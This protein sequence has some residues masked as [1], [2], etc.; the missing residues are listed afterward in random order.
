MLHRFLLFLT[1]LGCFALA[2]MAQPSDR[3]SSGAIQQ[4]LE[5]LNTLGTVLY[6]AAHPDD[7]NT[8]LISHLANGKHWR[9]AYFS[10]TRGD[11]GQ[12]LIGTEITQGLGVIRTQELLAARRLDGG[13]QFFSRA[14]DF[15]YSKH[16]DETFSVWD[17][18]QA[19]SDLVWV[20]RKLRPDVI[21]TRFSEEP[22]VTH[23][24][25]TASAILAH[26]AF[27]LANDP[28]AFPQ[29]LQWVQPWQ[30]AKLFWNIGLWSYRQSGRTFD[31]TGFVKE[32]VGGFNPYLGKSYTELSAAS[33][34]MHKS[35]G[36]GAS[37][38][39]GSE[40][41]YFQQW[42]GENTG[43]L[44]GGIPTGWG[45]VAGSERVAYYLSE[46]R[47][48]YDPAEPESIL[49]DLLNAR[50]ELMQLPDQHWKSVKLKE[51][52]TCIQSVTGTYMEVTA[53]APAYT[54]GDSVQLRLEVVNRTKAPIRLASARFFPAN[55]KL[56]YQLELKENQRNEFAL[57]TVLPKKTPYSGPYWLEHPFSQGMYYVPDQ[58][59]IGQAEN[60]PSLSAEFVL[61]LG[62]QEITYAVP[63]RYKRTDPVKGEVY[64]PVQVV[65]AVMVQLDDKALIFGSDQP[66]QV[67][68]KVIAGSQSQQGRVSLRVPKGWKVAPLSHDFS[69]TNRKDETSVAFSVSPPARGTSAGVISAVAEVN[70][71][72]FARGRKIIDYD[73]IPVQMMFPKAE[74]RA[75]KLELQRGHARQVG[76][77]MGAGDEVPE[78]LSELGY[79]VTLLENDQVTSENLAGLDAIMLGIRAFNTVPWLAQKTQTLFDYVEGGGT[80]VVQYNTSHQLVTPEIAP[81]PLRLSRK[82]V[83]VEGS[84]VALI[85]PDHPALLS[86]NKILEGDFD[87]WVQER[88]LYFPGEWSDDFT[89][90]LRMGDPGEEPTE[91]SVLVAR[92]GKGYYCYTGLS[93]F[94]QL[95]A[96]VPGAYRLLA[97]I[98]SL[99]SNQTP[100]Y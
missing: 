20:I 82:R 42:E 91:G 11:G 69:L 26:E 89:P 18:E 57:N 83:A 52:E 3:F 35:Q 66:R 38:S 53:A 71:E 7:E 25:H 96:G 48:S 31:E 77:I 4:Q 81:L 94:R 27:T 86:P 36:F 19:L 43:D 95:P 32:D 40:Y 16:P 45:R 15:G 97:N 100:E 50:R 88:G 39:R 29:Q 67:A 93:F 28:K 6:V 84:P 72:Q 98:L 60:A 70:G 9:T 68:V 34:S 22:G 12:N 55:E 73:H 78:I 59:Q 74:T 54:P 44:L 85:A 56:T 14:I 92:F 79:E 30:P 33:R 5:R 21:I 64:Q 41:E 17:R 51:I 23:G 90:L 37:A 46:A 13:E 47:D 76:Y 1:L 63:V 10:M 75:V 99:G 8:Q 58:H 87:G 62:E 61:S 65:P 24:H 80:L 2:L 49:S